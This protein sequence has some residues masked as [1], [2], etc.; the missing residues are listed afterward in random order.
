MKP[1]TDTRH[2]GRDWFLWNVMIIVV[3]GV[4]LHLGDWRWMAIV[5]VATFIGHMDAVALQAYRDAR[6]RDRFNAQQRGE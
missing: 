1:S 2:A 6:A 3:Y 4:A 5:A